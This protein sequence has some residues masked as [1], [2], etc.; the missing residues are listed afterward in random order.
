MSYWKIDRE[1]IDEKLTEIKAYIELL[2][3]K[4]NKEDVFVQMMAFNSLVALMP[5]KNI[6]YIISLGVKTGCEAA[7]LLRQGMA[8]SA[9]NSWVKNDS[10]R[11]PIFFDK[12]N[13]KLSD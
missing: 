4:L 1:Y 13:E 9:C 3:E 7:E 5:D 8:S 6:N 11:H 10:F 2:E 12:T